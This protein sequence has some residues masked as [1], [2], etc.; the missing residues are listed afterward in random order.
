MLPNHRAPEKHIVYMVALGH[1][2]APQQKWKVCNG[3]PLRNMPHTY[4]VCY[5]TTT[6]VL[7]PSSGGKEST[8]FQQG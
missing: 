6:M 8:R 5:Y 7:Q 2:A 1:G 3:G 4:L